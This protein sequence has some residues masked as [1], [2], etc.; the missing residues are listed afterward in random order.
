MMRRIKSWL[1]IRVLAAYGQSQ[2]SNYAS[3]LAFTCML[4]M[5]PL[6][7][8]VLSLIGYAVRD[9]GLEA[10][11]DAL[12]IEAFPGTAQPQLLDA[13]HGVRQSAGW[14]GLLSLA[15]LL[16]SA[17]SIFGTMEFALTQIFGTRQR[18][19]VRQKLMGLVM[20]IL[21]VV[22][23]GITVAANAVAALF[24]LAWV[25]GFMI[26]SAVMVGFLSLLYRFVPNRTFEVR[27]VLPGAL[28]A[29]I[30]IEVFS[31]GFPLYVRLAGGFNTYGAQFGLFFLLAAW[32][33]IVSELILFGAVFNQFRLGEPA[34]KGL[35]ASQ[36]YESRE[37]RKP[38]E[39]INEG[40]ASDQPAA[41]PRAK[42]VA[43]YFAVFRRRKRTTTT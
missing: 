28:L 32:F 7:L 11:A 33:Y 26:G 13:V 23:V 2:A 16:W 1:P 43:R 42:G 15:G 20:M 25:S 5:V 22:A 27:D 37:V 17:S 36:M 35:I 6:M 38:I 41:R 39:V 10:R 29:G 12:I 30:L 19:M 14:L 4:A 24:P 18:D 8:G 9:P 40:K 31:L 21:L 34:A 3:A